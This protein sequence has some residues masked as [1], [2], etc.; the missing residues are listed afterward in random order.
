MLMNFERAL[1]YVKVGGAIARK[2]WN[3]KG[4]SVH[5]QRPDVTSKMT[6]PYLYLQYPDG[7]KVPWL[8]SQTDLLSDDWIVAGTLGSEEEAS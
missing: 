3:G 5:M 8:A 4:L 2:G 6:L 1:S 7:T